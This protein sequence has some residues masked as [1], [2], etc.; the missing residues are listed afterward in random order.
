MDR[1]HSIGV[2][3]FN[4]IFLLLQDAPK[5][6]KRI[7]NTQKNRASRIAKHGVIN[8]VARV[9]HFSFTHKYCS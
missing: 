5:P 2:P 6:P 3:N 7:Y 8:G 4:E 1:I 9:I